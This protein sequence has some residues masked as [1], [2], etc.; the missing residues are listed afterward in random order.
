MKP[1]RSNDKTPADSVF[2]RLDFVISHSSFVTFVPGQP[3]I[4]AWPYPLASDRTNP[5]Y[6]AAARLDATVDRSEKVRAI[7]WGIEPSRWES[8]GILTR[9]TFVLRPRPAASGNPLRQG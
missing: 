6:A 5:Q 3:R 1:E 8:S 4:L 2:R 9:E 7:R